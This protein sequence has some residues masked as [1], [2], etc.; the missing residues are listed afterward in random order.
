M[1]STECFFAVVCKELEATGG[2]LV[3]V[4][5]S[6]RCSYAE[7]LGFRSGLNAPVIET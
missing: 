1:E 6:P 4:R 7:A 2:W 5:F 3:G